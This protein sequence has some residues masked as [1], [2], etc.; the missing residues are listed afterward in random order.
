MSQLYG[1][2]MAGNYIPDTPEPSSGWGSFLTDVLKGYTQIE[3]AKQQ[4]K[5]VQAQRDIA[6]AQTPAVL[7]N[8]TNRITG[9]ATGAGS[10]LLTLAIGAAVVGLLWFA[11]KGDGK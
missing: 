3:L 9:T 5:T 4:A 1:Y 8:F 7:P 10:L 11:F 6:V 2:D